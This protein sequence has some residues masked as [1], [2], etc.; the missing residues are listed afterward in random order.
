M[1]DHLL[2]EKSKVRKQKSTIADLPVETRASIGTYLTRDSDLKNYLNA[3][4]T[5][6]ART[7][8]DPTDMWFMKERYKKMDSKEKEDRLY[9]TLRSTL[10]TFGHER[11]ERNERKIRALADSG[12]NLN[13]FEILKSLAKSSVNVVKSVTNLMTQQQLIDEGLGYYILSKAISHGNLDVVRYMLEKIP[14][15]INSA[16]VFGS[17]LLHDA[18]EHYKHLDPTR[19][20][21]QRRIARML[22]EKMSQETINARD[23]EGKKAKDYVKPKED[24]LEIFGKIHGI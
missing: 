6:D 21:I 24:R 11:N 18:L 15:E 9:K 13:D 10:G 2:T 7:R 23:M 17:T 16:D 4:A 12:I 14:E 20:S 19:K 5:R 22:L 3:T 8:I 1:H